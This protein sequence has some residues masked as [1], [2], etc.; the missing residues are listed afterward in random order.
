VELWREAAALVVVFGLLAV[1]VWSLRQRGGGRAGAA[2]ALASVERLALT[3]QHTLH[4]VRIAGHELLL[5]THPQGC[6]LLSESRAPSNA[7]CR[8]EHA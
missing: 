1:A 4:R 8:E 7:L 5:A 3:P 6:T 2:K